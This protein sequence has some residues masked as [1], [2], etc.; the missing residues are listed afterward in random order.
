MIG[1]A[2]QGDGATRESPDLELVGER[3]RV[4]PRICTRLHASSAVSLCIRCLRLGPSVSA[5]WPPSS[6]ADVAAVSPVPVQMWPA[7]VSPVPVQILPHG[8]RLPAR[9]RRLLLADRPHRRRHQRERPPYRHRRGRVGDRARPPGAPKA[10]KHSD[11][12]CAVGASRWVG[13]A[14]TVA[15]RS[16]RGSAPCLLFRVDAFRLRVLDGIVLCGWMR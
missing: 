10:L 15:G 6:G 14:G 13:A 3:A 9:R 7:G 1:T 4:V 2:K 12:R 11:G 8:R 16:E 5:K